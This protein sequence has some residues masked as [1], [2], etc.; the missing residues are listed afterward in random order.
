MKVLG[1]LEHRDSPFPDID[2]RIINECHKLAV[3]PLL[4]GTLR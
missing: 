3:L 1:H 2:Y 4:N